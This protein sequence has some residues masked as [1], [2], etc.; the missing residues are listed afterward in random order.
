MRP[1]R[2]VAESQLCRA[3]AG[4]TKTHS[5]R[6]NGRS[7]LRSEWNWRAVVRAWMDDQLHD[8]QVRP[9]ETNHERL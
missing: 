2:D 3:F 9:K 6:L 8:N 1:R 5:W 4:N 7:I